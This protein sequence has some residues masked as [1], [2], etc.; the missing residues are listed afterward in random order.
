MTLRTLSPQLIQNW[1][2]IALAP[3]HRAIVRGAVQRSNEAFNRLQSRPIG[4]DWH[5]E[6]SIEGGDF[7]SATDPSLQT[8]GIFLLDRNAVLEAIKTEHTRIAL[9]KAITSRSSEQIRLLWSWSWHG[10]QDTAWCTEFGFDGVIHDIE[11]MDRWSRICVRS[12]QV[13]ESQT[14][15]LLAGIRLPKFK[16]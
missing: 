9:T 12:G 3:M 2:L 10:N 8:S 4:L 6:S 5:V 7:R 14:N 13:H 1:T 16:T 11:S 15:P